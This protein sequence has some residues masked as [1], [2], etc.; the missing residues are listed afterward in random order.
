SS[1]PD[2]Y[3]ANDPDSL[4]EAGV[5]LNAENGW[6]HVWGRL[7]DVDENGQAIYYFVLETSGPPHFDVSYEGNGVS[8]GLILVRNTD[9]AYALPETGGAG[10]GVLY[11]LGLLLLAAAAIWYFKSRK[12]DKIVCSQC[13]EI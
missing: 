9:S 5:V 3:D 1:S 8:T 13:N 7:P 11:A 2:S 6:S 4:V 12:A 10:Q